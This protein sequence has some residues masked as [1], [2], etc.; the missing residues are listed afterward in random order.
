MFAMAT[1]PWFDRSEPPASDS[2]AGQDPQQAS[3]KSGPEPA[4]AAAP[5]AVLVA[6][7]TGRLAAGRRPEQAYLDVIAIGADRRLAAIAVCAAAGTPWP[8][9][10]SRMA[11]FDDIWSSLGSGSAETAGSLLELYG[12]FDLEVELDPDQAQIATF[13]RQAMAAVTY[14]PSGYANGLYRMLRTGQLREAMLSLEE[15]GAKRWA[16]NRDFWVGLT[17]AATR[18]DSASILDTDVAAVRRRCE[19]RI[20][21]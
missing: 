13:L 16:D 14:L 20:R 11:A 4:Q 9:A 12:F 15:M 1:N 8:E 19:S 6:F 2:R 18:L 21:S 5:D 17:E 10:L 7:A 3:S